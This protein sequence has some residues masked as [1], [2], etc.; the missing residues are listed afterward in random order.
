MLESGYSDEQICEYFE[1]DILDLGA[2]YPTYVGIEIVDFFVEY[3]WNFPSSD[4][5]RF[6][7]R[8]HLISDTNFRLKWGPFGWYE[9][10]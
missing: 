2:Y 9:D 8:Q 7:F 4:I 6:Q 5:A 3:F 1:W 10:K